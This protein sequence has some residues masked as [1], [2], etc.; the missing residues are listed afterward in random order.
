MVMI[1]ELHKEVAKPIPCA[2]IYLLGRGKY[3][4]HMICFVSKMNH[5]NG[6]QQK[7]SVLA[8]QPHH[9]YSRYH[10]IFLRLSH[11]FHL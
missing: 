7:L 4:E 8:A 11:V 5:E 3:S 10:L 2:Q 1:L 9:L 6:R